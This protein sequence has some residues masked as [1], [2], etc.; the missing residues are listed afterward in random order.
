MRH[1]TIYNVRIPICLKIFLQ[2][3]L[4]YIFLITSSDQPNNLEQLHF[5]LKK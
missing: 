3:W 1:S 4:K 5:H 2:D